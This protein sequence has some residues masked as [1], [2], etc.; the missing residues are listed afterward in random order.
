M[1]PETKRT[2]GC[3]VDSKLQVAPAK[4]G[5]QLLRRVAAQRDIRHERQ[6]VHHS[7]VYSEYLS[8]LSL[9]A[10]KTA[11][12]VQKLNEMYS[13]CSKTFGWW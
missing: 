4:V 10:F 6:G 12:A 2:G 8:L 9:G 3:K 7:L 1:R 13:F 5:L 11:P